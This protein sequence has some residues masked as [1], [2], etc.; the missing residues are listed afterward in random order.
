MKRPAKGATTRDAI[1]RRG[2]LKGAGAAGA[3]L[4]GPP[5]RRPVKDIPILNNN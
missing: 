1:G 5:G 4:Q 3:A 2:F